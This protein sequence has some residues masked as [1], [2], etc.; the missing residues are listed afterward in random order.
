MTRVNMSDDPGPTHNPRRRGVAMLLVLIA[1]GVGVV[2]AG[3]AITSRKP[4]PRIG[5]NACDDAAARWAAQ[6][7]AS[8]AQAVLETAIDCVEYSKDNS[9]EFIR[10]FPVEGGV[11]NVRLT[12]LDGSAPQAGDR[13]LLMTAVANIGSMTA[14]VQKRVSL[15]NPVPIDTAADIRLSEFAVFAGNS[16]QID[17]NAIV[18]HSEKV[19][20]DGMLT[21]VKLGVGFSSLSS[22][23]VKN[24][25]DL[26]HVAMYVDADASSTLESEVGGG[27]FYNGM[28]IPYSIPLVR[29][30]TRSE[31]LALPL[32]SSIL[33]LLD[34]VVQTLTGGNYLTINVQNGTVLT[35]GTA[36]QQ[37]V[38]KT[39]SLTVQ[40]GGVLR[41]EGEVI[42]QVSG[43]TS[44]SN[45]GTIEPA[46]SS[47]RLLMYLGRNVTIQDSAI[48]L[49]R[50][51]GQDTSRTF[52]S[53]GVHARADQVYLSTLTT[54]SGG[55]AAPSWSIDK[56]AL[57]LG[58]IF[59][60][61]ASVT[62]NNKSALIGRVVCGSFTL[63][64]SCAVYYDPRL[65]S[66]AGFTE[67]DGPLYVERAP[68]PEVVTAFAGASASSGVQVLQN[69]L[70]STLNAVW[71]AE[72]E[73][74][75]LVQTTPIVIPVDPEDDGS[76]SV[77][78]EGVANRRVRGRVQLSVQPSRAGTFEDD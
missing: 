77:D 27:K 43:A 14:T 20:E 44:I 63:K 19:A 7:A 42:L 55:S 35:L 58:S 6:G 66:R 59:A 72:P 51:I 24:D 17:S 13:E 68:I 70:K 75:I 25:A 15:A 37:S 11:A 53:V 71:A 69:T 73:P 47:A 16:M 23:D 61:D 40:N 48:G 50:A 33:T 21:P 22:L 1:L 32:L 18:A 60:P 78:E 67:L 46:S 31:V 9:G 41:F 54:S 28:K 38:F 2:L 56:S 52:D 5:A 57:V 49:P 4:A 74:N 36:G 45:R 39:S 3:V 30:A 62:V 26:K 12:R 76:V 29:E 34:G 64:S 8:Y 10:T 65:D